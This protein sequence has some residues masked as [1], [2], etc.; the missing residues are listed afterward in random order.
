M[1]FG[2][3]LPLIDFTGHPVTLQRI[4]DFTRTAEQ[5]GYKTLCANDHLVFPR[6]WFDGPTA[7][8]AVLEHTGQMNL[9]TTVSLP[10]IRGPVALAK[11]MSAIDLL[12]S[13]RL[14]GGVGPGS[15]ERDYATVGIPFDERWKRL[16]EAVEVMRGLWSENNAPFNGDFYSTEGIELKPYPH[17]PSGPPL[18]IGSWG[19][20]AGLR[21][22]A[23]LADGWLASAYNIT[24][25]MFK[26]ALQKLDGYLQD[27][28]KISEHFPNAIAT[29][30]CYVTED[31]AEADRVIR[32][33][34]MPAV[35]R[36]EDELRA[37]LPI[38]P[39]EEC[40]EKLSAYQAAGAQ[41]VFIWPV[42]DE[43]RQLEVFHERVV[44]L[45]E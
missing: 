30:F 7:L 10:I 26:D 24:P 5:L 44:P 9:A 32:N 15:S 43:V 37:R 18:W 21:R 22:V 28:G 38:G 33:I 39:A 11:T 19:S 45:V 2:A 36:P 35:P 12:S 31:R 16:D 13:G 23:R 41:K 14:I 40:A 1:E 20:P 17:Q 3:H 6:P 8:S 42:D 34:I 4:I 25:E 27:A 29:S